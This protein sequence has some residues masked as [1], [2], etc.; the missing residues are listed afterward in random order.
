MRRSVLATVILCLVLLVLQPLQ[1]MAAAVE[2][3]VP[4]QGAG[5]PASPTFAAAQPDH[6]AQVAPEGPDSRE[7]AKPERAAASAPLFIE[8]VGQFDEGA[9]F[10]MWGGPGTTWL[11]EDGIWIT[12]LEPAPK[13]D[14][15][16]AFEAGPQLLDGPDETPRKAVHLKLSFVGA[17]PKPRLEPYGR[18]ETKV[19]YFIGAD[20]DE[21]HPDVPVWSGVRYVDLYP[22]IDLVLGTDAA[23]SSLP[24]S[25]VCRT[26]WQSALRDVRLRVEGA[27]TIELLSADDGRAESLRLRTAVGELTLL[28]LPVVAV[29]ASRAQASTHLP[30]GQYPT[31]QGDLIL[32]PFADECKPTP[33]GDAHLLDDPTDLRYATFLGGGSGDYG[34]GIAVD[35]AGCAY[36]TGDT[37]SVD[38]PAAV[39][40]GY[41]PSFNGVYDAYVVKLDA[42]GTAL[43]YATF[44]GGTNGDDGIAIAVDG[45][46][47]AYVTG[48]TSSSDF[49][50]ASGPGYDTSYNGGWD[51]YAVKLDAAGTGIV[52]ATFLGGETEDEGRD[53][54]VDGAGCAYVTGQTYSADFPAAGG[55]GYDTSYNGS[56][57]SYD[58]YV[59]K[60]EMGSGGAEPT[61]APPTASLMPT[62]TPSPTATA[63]PTLSPSPQPT[64]TATPTPIVTCYD[65]RPGD[66]IYRLTKN[67]FRGYD[68]DSASEA[69]LILVA[70]PVAPGGWNQP[71]FSPNQDWQPAREVWWDD[72]LSAGWGPRIEGCPIIGLSGGSQP[73]GIAGDT[74]LVRRTFELD[75]PESNR[76][77]SRAV[78]QMW[79]DN[80]TAWYWQGELLAYNRET[81]VGEVELFPG[82]VDPGGGQYVLAVQNSNDFLHFDANPQGTAF[83]LCVT[84]A[85][86][87][88]GEYTVALPLILK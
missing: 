12:L 3:K 58:A 45:E 41:D 20:P 36:V 79:S 26:D 1:T 85:Y 78:L 22:G 44:L 7:T 83:R 80:K 73:Q 48:L 14:P 27:E 88:G 70:E 61:L 35:G 29:D 52:Y 53:V 13:R 54:A 15:A 62:V 68:E 21:W 24:W 16:E 47:N 76:R 63:T 65:S 87:G 11:A 34:Y 60:L 49:P 51:A 69:D 39:G 46:G 19:S 42:S 17:N 64:S 74:H 84:W 9:R 81:Y 66:L 67:Q 10:Q 72:W 57:G 32:A 28:L 23:G 71:G 50:A 8:N 82:R 2:T 25:R 4:R 86:P 5:P 6:R 18:L 55:P 33:A 43:L 56:Y 75:P 40:P 37:N 59:A 30:E 77:I 31:L 38:F